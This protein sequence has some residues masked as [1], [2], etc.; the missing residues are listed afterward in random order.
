MKK[1]GQSDPTH[2]NILFTIR[3]MSAPI[4]K[5]K[6]IILIIIYFFAPILSI[7]AQ[8]LYGMTFYGGNYRGGTINKFLPAAN[9]L[10]VSKSFEFIDQPQFHSNFIQA[11]DGKL[12]GMSYN[13]NNGGYDYSG[14]GCI[15]SFDPSTSTYTNLRFFDKDNGA[16]P[17]GSLM[18]ASDG[19][20]YGMT[21]QGGSSNRGVI[22]SFDPST[23]IYT[24]LKDF[25]GTNGAYPYGSLIQAND[26][27]LY[28]MTSNGGSSDAGVIFSFD[29]STSTYAKLKDFDITNGCNPYGSLMQATN[30]KLY[31]TTTG[32]GSNGYGVIFSF[33]PSSYTYT[34]LKDFDNTCFNTNNHLVQAGN[35]K[36]YGMTFQG[37]ID[38]W[39]IFSFDPSTSTYTKLKDID[40]TRNSNQYSSLTQ[41]S[42]GKLYGMINGEVG[43]GVGVIF[44]FD[45]LASTYAKLKDFDCIN[46]CNANGIL[47]QASDGK[48][49][50]ITTNGGISN[51][52]VI[53][54]FDPSASAYTAVKDF[55]NT[56]GGYP[57]GSLMQASNGK[58]YGMT[59]SGGSGVGVIFSFDPSSSAYTKL[60]DFDDAIGAV[61][62]GSLVQASDGKLYGMSSNGGS[63]NRGVIFS[64]D[65]SSFTYTKLKDFDG[66]GDTNGGYP[67]GS[68]MQA[69]DGKL[70]G[71][72]GSGY[73]INYAVLFS[74]NPSTSVY[75]KLKVFYGDY[76]ASNI[77]HLVQARNGKIYGPMNWAG[78]STANFIY[79]FDP[80]TSI[81][82]QT[83]I[84]PANGLGPSGLMQATDGKALWHDGRWWKQQ[85]RCYFFL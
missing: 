66:I 83:N 47:L 59:S 12:Y 69:S 62:Q 6:K 40:D 18:Q 23:S 26:G 36:L 16:Y 60:K 85:C 58:L 35:G 44:S 48:L 65:P 45:P 46:G 82:T 52:G 39:I 21:N 28:G 72:T 29:P 10:T 24:K 25:D 30:G 9:N 55:D 15:F 51:V 43:S 70:Y 73:L 75:T 74:F 37:G 11:T 8:T 17:Y 78:S 76:I 7:Q 57:F 41:A 79:S 67:Q 77:G 31:G 71:I 61:P 4:I 13:G 81:Y 5:M 34:K 38:L 3:I 19:R 33:D 2:K 54:S 32:G 68:L 49:Y 50:G 80:S 64:F 42:D 27:K 22:F 63:F 84:D 56:N 53:F 14:G 20:L 1:T